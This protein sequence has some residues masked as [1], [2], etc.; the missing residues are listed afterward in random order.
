MAATILIAGCD[1]KSSSSSATPPTAQAAQVIAGEPFTSSSTGAD[2]RTAS[3]EYRKQYCERMATAQQKIKPG[4]TG[5]FLF[6]SLQE[7]YTTTEKGV[8]NTKIV[9]I[10]A[11]TVAASR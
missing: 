8:L 11:L 5:Q 10:I 1:K 2:W 9:E 4:I 3:L 7:F 6:D